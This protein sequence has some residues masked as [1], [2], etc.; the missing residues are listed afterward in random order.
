MNKI[1]LTIAL[2]ITFFTFSQNNLDYK[3]IGDTVYYNKKHRPELKNNATYFSII[4]KIETVKN[5]H[6]FIFDMYCLDTLDI[7]KSIK[8]YSS[9]TNYLESGGPDGTTFYYHKNGK[10][11]STGSMEQGWNVGKWTYYYDNGND[12]ILFHETFFFIR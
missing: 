3:N 7:K 2:F 5:K 4:K 9:S 8:E 11:K 12:C 1:N 10:I 6:K